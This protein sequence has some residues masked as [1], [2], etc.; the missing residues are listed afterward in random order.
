MMVNGN[1]YVNDG[2]DGACI[3]LIVR[4]WWI[5]QIKYDS[6]DNNPLRGGDYEMVIT[7]IK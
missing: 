2:N 5:R 4:T 6:M 1:D 7:T 3:C